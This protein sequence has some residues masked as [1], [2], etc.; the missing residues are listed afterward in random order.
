MILNSSSSEV[1]CMKNSLKVFLWNKYHTP[2]NRLCTW[3][4]T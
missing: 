1:L 4:R 2:S 3:M